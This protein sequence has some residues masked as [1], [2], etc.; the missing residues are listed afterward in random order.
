M[1]EGPVAPRYARALFDSA[2]AE[3]VVDEALEQVRGLASLIQEH[4][5]LRE[6]LRNPHVDSQEKADLLGR[7]LQGARTE[8][9][10][11]FVQLVV[12]FGR[13][14]ELPEI[15]EAFQGLVDA[16]RHTVR[17]VVRSAYPLPAAVLERLRKRLEHRQQQ[18][19]ILTPEVDA[20][21]LGGVQ[22]VLD[23]HVI[24]ASVRRQLEE[25]RQRLTSVRV[26]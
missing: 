4:P 7:M 22:I 15:A 3:G 11:A 6:L 18:Q 24:D 12:S 10:R 9:V 14:E 1:A 5:S 25:L 8:P 17:A 16:Q 21:L 20:A 23:H 2:S 19:V 13:A 26:Y